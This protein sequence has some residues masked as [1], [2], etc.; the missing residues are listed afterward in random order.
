MVTSADG[1]WRLADAP[2][3]A[4]RIAAF[5]PRSS[6]SAPVISSVLE[7]GSIG[8]GPQNLVSRDGANIHGVI[9]APTYPGLRM[10]LRISADLEDVTVVASS[11]VRPNGEYE[12]PTVPEGNYHL[13][14][15]YFGPSG[16]CLR[17]EVE[18][19][20]FAIHGLG[21]QLNVRVP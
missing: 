17:A 3:G 10:E 9:D 19:S 8:D 2:V 11:A 1:R 12:S 13:L 14:L 16:E 20:N 15:V 7:N 21:Q 4:I 18:P 5:P 6:K